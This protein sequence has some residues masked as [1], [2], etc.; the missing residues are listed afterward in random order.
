MEDLY[1][2]S[3]PDYPTDL[4]RH[5]ISKRHVGWDG[6]LEGYTLADGTYVG[7]KVRV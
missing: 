1:V 5:K 4:P 7:I 2:S 3:L 6:A